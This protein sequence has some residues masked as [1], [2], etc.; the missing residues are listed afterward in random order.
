MHYNQAFAHRSQ[1]RVT[2]LVG[3][4]VAAA[5]SDQPVAPTGDVAADGG[6]LGGDVDRTLLDLR[7]QVCCLTETH[8]ETRISLYRYYWENVK[9]VL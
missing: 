1:P 2:V 3:G 6:H 9:Y 5:C 4:D 7:L 8:R